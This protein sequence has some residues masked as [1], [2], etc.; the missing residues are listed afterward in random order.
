M[1]V[2]HLRICLTALLMATPIGAQDEPKTPAQFVGLK[3]RSIGPAAGGRVSRAVGVTGDPLTYYAATAG[4]GVWKSED[5]GVHFKPIFDDQLDSSIGSIAVAPSDPNIVY[6]GAG[7]ANIRGNVQ[8]GHGIYKST[9]A[10]KTW[11]QVWKQ[12]GQMGTI[13]VHPKDP[14]TAYAAVLGH[15]FGP[16]PERGVYRTR[17][18]GRTWDRVLFKDDDTGA[19]DVAIDV[20]NPR[21]L[22]AGLWT[23]RRKP[24]DLTSGGPGS[25]LHVSRDGGDTWQQLGP[26]KKPRPG[27]KKDDDD[28]E[29]TLPPGPWGKVCVAI[30]PSNSNR[31]YANIEAEKGGLYRSDDGG[32][33]WDR[34]S[35]SQAIRQRAWYFSTITVHPQIE[36]IVYCPQVRMQRSIDGG[37]TFQAMKGFAHGDHHD[38]WVDPTN[39]KR[40]VTANDGGIDISTDGGKS[41]RSPPLPVCQFYHINCDNAAPYN[42]MGCMQDMG[43]A[44]GPSDS[45]G[46]SITL[47]DWHN[48]GGGETGF[49]VPDPSDPNIVYAGEY[50]GFISR[51][52]HR[53]RTAR[54]VGVYPY[55][56]S[57]HGAE[58]LKY[59]FQ[60]TAPILISKHDPKMVYHAANVLFRT[61]NGGQTWDK[62]SS[63]LTRNDKNKQKWTGGP[64]TGDNTGVEIYG[65]IF[66]IAESPLNKR[67]FWCGSDDGFVHVSEDSCSS[68]KNVTPNIPDLPDW[69]SVWCIEASPFDEGTAYVVVNAA[70]LDDHRPHVWVTANF[71]ETWTKLNEG[72]PNDEAVRV[73][74]ADPKKKGHLYIGTERQVWH[75]SDG[76]SEWDPLK[77]NLPT[78]AVTDIVVKDNDLVI[79]TQGR[80]VWI[81]DDITPIREWTDAV[82]KKNGQVFTS[83]PTTRWNRA[84]GVTAHQNV[85]AA[86]NPPSGAVITYYL[87]DKAKRPITIEVFDEKN[88]KVVRIEGKDKKA[89]KDAPPEADDGE[90]DDDKK[91]EI[92]GDKGINRFVWDMRHQGAEVIEKAKLDAGNPKKGPRV[93]PGV[94]TIKVIADGKT[95]SG[96]MEVKM[97]PR[98]TEP[99]GVQVGKQVPQKIDI[100]PRVADPKDAAKLENAPGILRRN[101]LD[102]VR[103]EAKE[104]EQFALKLRDD[105]TRLTEIVRELRSIRK[106]VELHQQILEKQTKAKAFL[107]QE[108]ELATKL[109]E[110]EAKLHNPKAKV[111]YDILAQKG[112]AK[113]YSQLSALLDFAS[114]GEGP[115]TQGMKEL[116]E[117]FEKELAER[118]EEYQKLKTGEVAKLNDLAQKLK[119]P[120][121]WIPARPK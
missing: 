38:Y 117:E 25:S 68:W 12:V 100:A 106:Q 70:R 96:K 51:Y 1:T 93:A 55:D 31:I 56:P 99:R 41:W 80:S 17:D 113:L 82:E 89:D 22:F 94:Y 120:M 7:E 59:R 87:K 8:I 11:K 3:Y 5:G 42:V 110:L 2:H 53:T 49:A 54:H 118:D 26:E 98:V 61:T 83:P 43:T 79:G 97:D 15:A 52:D 114:D 4:G 95:F 50:G 40:M 48:V 78:V 63:D 119:V 18:G 112:G 62:V 73:I 30:A 108:K 121:I 101:N 102:V 85:A 45:L 67:I 74:R 66:A 86:D 88:K 36:D 29:S 103:D 65:T 115:P 14:E 33:S 92:P 90:E 19:S 76:G 71:G 60:W 39:P 16:N 28:K 77:L 107:K 27:K 34:V 57:G 35:D 32:E 91:P 75:S 21:V 47:G 111:V 9:D 64:I 6:V 105:I 10:G 24:W 37:K 72:L 116:A 58:E 44:A 23:A 104:Q 69:G 20:N 46:G 81:L 84:G 109:D 13:V